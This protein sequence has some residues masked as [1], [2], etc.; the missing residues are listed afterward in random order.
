MKI[1]TVKLFMETPIPFILDL[2]FLISLGLDR[3][4]QKNYKISRFRVNY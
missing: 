1:R 2:E 4:T 3:K